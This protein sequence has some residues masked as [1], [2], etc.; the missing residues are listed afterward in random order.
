MRT[1][2]TSACLTWERSSV[3]VRWRPPLSVTIVT[4]LVTRSLA[5]GATI[6]D[7]TAIWMQTS[8]THQDQSTRAG[9]Q[10][11]LWR[12]CE[13]LRVPCCFTFCCT[14]LTPKCQVSSVRSHKLRD[15][16]CEISNNDPMTEKKGCPAPPMAWADRFR[17]S[18]EIRR[19]PRSLVSAVGVSCSAAG[20]L[21][22]L[23]LLPRPSAYFRGD[24]SV[25]QLAGRSRS[26]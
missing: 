4:H 10:R 11:C 5:G 6:R 26:A 1:A 15:Y 12:A 3:S 20:S 13:R 2:S 24:G 17:W 22:L 16:W 14:K 23:P 19:D 8:G 18:A 7:R 9:S 21:Q 25:T